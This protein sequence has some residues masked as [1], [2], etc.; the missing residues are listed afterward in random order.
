MDEKKWSFQYPDNK[1]PYVFGAENRKRQADAAEKLADQLLAPD[2]V[3]QPLLRDLTDTSDDEDDE[4]PVEWRRDQLVLVL[5]KA[6]ELITEHEFR[7]GGQVKIHR[8]PEI[9]RF[10]PSTGLMFSAKVHREE[11][12]AH[13]N[14]T[15]NKDD[16]G[17]DSDPPL[18]VPKPQG[19]VILVL[20][21]GVYHYEL[22]NKF[23]PV[24]HPHFN[25]M[26]LRIDHDSELVCKAEV[27]V[28]A[29]EASPSDDIYKPDPE[30]KDVF[31]ASPWGP[32]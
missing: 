26:E 3:I 9:A 8:L 14:Q 12:K 24:N 6:V 4:D 18:F 20:R 16:G 31:Y 29:V 13:L 15:H 5:Q 28:E 32:L 11:R 19:R 2:S 23:Y 21:P 30:D 17:T 27:V 1:T 25:R 7:L 22:P 10:D